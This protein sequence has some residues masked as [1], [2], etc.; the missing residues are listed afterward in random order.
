[1]AKPKHDAG[2][3]C[4]EDTYSES[5]PHLRS[6]G[7]QASSYVPSSEGDDNSY[8]LQDD[9][10]V[11]HGSLANKPKAPKIPLSIATSPPVAKVNNLPSSK[12]QN[13]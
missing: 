13:Q 11:S 10:E 7:K 1:M 9:A 2:S 4:S 8:D 12:F 6:H 3:K 5:L